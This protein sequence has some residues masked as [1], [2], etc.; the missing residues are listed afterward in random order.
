MV[1]AYR[2]VFGEV[3]HAHGL[4]AQTPGCSVFGNLSAMAVDLPSAAPAGISWSPFLRGWS[5]DGHYLLAHTQPDSNASRPGMVR[6][7][8]L[9]IPI[10]QVEK[11]VSV[12]EAIRVL[13]TPWGSNK[14]LE[15]VDFADQDVV[16]RSN[17]GAPSDLLMA[18]MRSLVRNAGGNTPPI[19]RGQ[20]GFDDLICDLWKRLPA[21]WKGNLVFG[22]SFV[23]T[24]L[25]GR[26]LLLGCCPS[27]LKEAW[28]G[29]PQIE[30]SDAGVESMN[31]AVAYLLSTVGGGP[32]STLIQDGQLTEPSLL[33][34]ASYERAARAWKNLG[35]LS[36]EEACALLRDLTMLAPK[37]RLAQG[38]KAQVVDH[39]A[40]FLSKCSGDQILSLRNIKVDALGAE[41]LA[42]HRGIS[43]WT[44][45]RFQHAA[46]EGNSDL[47]RVAEASLGDANGEW[48]EAV[49][50]GTRVALESLE[51]TVYSI[52]WSLWNAND[53]YFENTSGLIASGSEAEQILIDAIPAKVS[54]ALGVK[55]CKYSVSRSYWLLHAVVQLSMV[56][57][58][59]AVRAQLL[60]DVDRNSLKGLQLICD[61]APPSE[62]IKFAGELND[63]RL[64]QLGASLVLQAP[65]LLS[66]FS[67][68]QAGWIDMLAR[69]CKENPELLI[70]LAN[71]KNIVFD[72]LDAMVNG[73]QIQDSLLEALSQTEH[74][75][76]SDYPNRTK[77]FAQL[78]VGATRTLLLRQTAL[79]LFRK[80]LVTPAD[81]QQLDSSMRAELLSVSCN[82]KRFSANSPNLLDGGLKLFTGQLWLTEA[83]CIEWLEVVSV[84][85]AGFDISQIKALVYL[86]K[87]RGWWA[88]ISMLRSKSIVRMDFAEAWNVYWSRLSLIEKWLQGS[89]RRPI[90]HQLGQMTKAPEEKKNV[91]ALFVTALGTEF[92]AVKAHL[93]D[94]ADYPINGSQ[95]LLGYFNHDGVAT[96]VLVI[97]TGPGNEGAAVETERAIHEGS[98]R[99]GFFVGIAGG[100]KKEMKLGDVVAAT[101]VY[102]YESGKAKKEFEPRP[103]AP[104]VSHAA[105]QVAYKVER[106][107]TW[108]S[109]IASKPVATPNAY[110]KPVASSGKVI[111]SRQ[112]AEYKLIKKTYGD[113]YA[114]AMEDLG[115]A[116]A[117]HANPSVTFA[118]VRG[119]SDFAHRKA[120]AELQN[121]QEIAA[122]H[123]AAFAFE[124]LSVFLR[125]SRVSD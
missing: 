111:D 31:N 110:V 103:I 46:S 78:S 113:S 109:R 115:F 47:Q 60:V 30:D 61:A 44:T 99:W 2:A 82:G 50:A 10:G 73:A 12:E 87:S 69:A 15:V 20:E 121:S 83:Q 117:A 108:Q 101:K 9:A 28:R 77:F 107:S 42:L 8:V 51:P 85:E 93:S 96:P 68:S 52:A 75:D 92:N 100:L 32:I 36:F 11:L 122:R 7:Q 119:I 37:A 17:W 74:A 19:V 40:S 89:P 105:Q 80:A 91:T 1:K 112:S 13:Q 27:G 54:N 62:F 64:N 76:L 45:A 120:E 22:F 3:A 33:N 94:H 29:Y 123:A 70:G 39:L 79:G 95:G 72:L 124:M 63:E 84:S 38:L 114:V 90:P 98:P 104:E 4:I 6:T 97:Q 23:P 16:T 86:L 21:T 25:A 81:V 26:G 65:D 48:I 55:V 125:T 116:R 106:E 35:Q 59:K 58:K 118:V 49:Q 18:V 102:G 66:G 67:A 71:A 57:W 5:F 53:Q 43:E 34:L 14:D 88:G 41:T 56:G 24:D